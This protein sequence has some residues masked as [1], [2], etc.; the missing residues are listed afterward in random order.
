MGMLMG[1]A[2]RPTVPV[3]NT[4][5]PVEAF[6][7]LIG[8]LANQATTEYQAMTAG[9]EAIVPRYLMNAEGEFVV[10]PAV[11][12]QRAGRLLE[13]I[14]EAA[15]QEA[16]TGR[17]AAGRFHAETVQELRDEEN[18]YLLELAEIYT[19]YEGLEE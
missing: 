5:V 16:L 3:R 10:D 6:T 12:E 14:G 9:R 4:A 8:V 7:N 18:Y 2:G 17:R 15:R 11:P 19:S 1:N 13:L